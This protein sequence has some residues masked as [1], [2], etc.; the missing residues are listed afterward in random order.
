M[1]VSALYAHSDE[2]SVIER[3]IMAQGM[4]FETSLGPLSEAGTGANLMRSGD[5]G[6]VSVRR[7]GRV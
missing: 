5:S 6:K 1:G 7:W 3:W 2:R 4:C